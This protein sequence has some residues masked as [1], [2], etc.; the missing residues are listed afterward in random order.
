MDREA[1][2]ALL[3]VR[4]GPECPE[5]NLRELAW[6]SNPHCGIAIPK[7]PNQR[8]H[9]D[10]SQDKGLSR[11]SQL[12]TGPSPT[13]ASQSQK[14][15]N[16]G[17]REVSY[18]KMLA[19]FIASQD[20]LGFWMVDIAGRVAARDQLPRRD[21]GHIW[22]GTPIVYPEN[23]AAGTGKAISGSLQ[24]GVTVLT[25]HLVTW[26]AWTWDG[27]KMQAQP[28]L[29]LCGVPE[30]LNLRGLDLGSACNPGPASESSQRSNLEPE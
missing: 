1:R 15:G 10:C 11:A 9:E 6:D 4:T 16:C 29:H 19:D 25:K 5:G 12:Q 24:L 8:H 3:R 7:S 18:T 17:P 28:S 14:G 2:A 21:I 30:N 26:A 13:R 22:E 23:Q 20:F 27:H